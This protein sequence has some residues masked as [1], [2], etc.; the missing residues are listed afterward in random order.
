MDETWVVHLNSGYAT[1]VSVS[2]FYE[3]AHSTRWYRQYFWVAYWCNVSL[4]HFA[5]PAEVSYIFSK[6]TEKSVQSK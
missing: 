6:A 4:L 3:F 1:A 5:L 2:L